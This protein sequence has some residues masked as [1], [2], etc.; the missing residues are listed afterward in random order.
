MVYTG[1][2]SSRAQNELTKYV[3]KFYQVGLFD[4]SVNSDGT[5]S[6]SPTTTESNAVQQ[7][8]DVKWFLS[9]QA[10]S[11]NLINLWNNTGG[12]QD[13]FISE[14]KRLM[15]DYP[16]CAGIDVDF[17]QGGSSAYTTMAV[18]FYQRIS[19][20]VHAEGKLLHADLPGLTGPG[21][22][23]GGEYWCD[24]GKLA[25]TFDTCTIMSYGY[26][27]AGS[28]PGPIAPK[29]WVDNVYDYAVTQIPPEKVF[30]GVA[31]YGYRW[32]IDH[33]PSGYRGS[34]GTYYAYLAWML[35]V[36]NHSGGSGSQPLIPWA[37]L[38]DDAEKSPYMF[39]DIYD[40]Q[41]PEDATAVNAP[42][43]TGTYNG[44]DFVT[45]YN[46]I[47][48]TTFNSQVVQQNATDY[49]SHS[50]ALSIQ[51]DHISAEQPTSTGSPGQATYSFDIGTAGTYEIVLKVNF[52][53]WDEAK[54]GISIDGQALSVSQ[55]TQ[56]Y[57]LKR[58]VHWMSAG[59]ISLSTGSHTLTFE[60]SNSDYGA[61]F[62][63]FNVCSSFSFHMSGGSIDYDLNPQT[64][65]DVNGNEVQPA[66]GYDLSLEILR[67]EPTPAGVWNDDFRDYPGY[68]GIPLSNYYST[69]SGWS[70]SGTYGSPSTLKGSGELTLGY[71]GFGDLTVWA[72]FSFS[73]SEAGLVVGSNKI[74]LTDTGHVVF[75]GQ[76][77]G[78][79]DTSGSN[80]LKVRCRSGTYDVWLNDNLIGSKSSAGESNK[81]GVYTNSGSS[82]SCT[83]LAAGDAYWMQPQE[84]IT[85]QTPAGTETLGRIS[86]SGV[87]WD[88]TW[89]FF[90]VPDGTEEI[91]TRTGSNTTISKDFDYENSQQISLLSDIPITIAETDISVWL[92][93]VFLCDIDGASIAYYCD[94]NYFRYWA[95]QAEDQWNLNGTAMWQLGL[96]DPK[97]FPYIPDQW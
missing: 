89:G 90:K 72:D 45:T 73:G 88:D 21:Q 20:T 28:A 19:D 80:T 47:Q 3:K 49:T 74:G 43:T 82:M 37:A 62:Y 30:M 14:I 54:I 42:A 81:F 24:Y 35:G 23:L 60:G 61:E 12:A 93:R 57:P 41:W 68:Q 48:E 85:V 59:S 71:T 96:E 34:S 1:D 97:I 40:Y 69:P 13:T 29:S 53:W 67:H 51:S 8:P 86:R 2:N 46:K 9:V 11:S 79:A 6:G 50:G 77:I 25:P 58:T 31:G 33:K 95:D 56:W 66:S 76:L 27:Y 18:N 63:T 16:W 5:I 52:P 17:E 15:S 91:N 84:A 64:Y 83:K 44:Y 26:S 75:N 4:F 38:W 94:L 39:L 55:P 10:L 22:S 78:S 92:K 7:F 32:E 36:F 65:V 70:V 87:T